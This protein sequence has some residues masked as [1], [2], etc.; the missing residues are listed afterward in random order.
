MQTGELLKFPLPPVPIEI[1]ELAASELEVNIHMYV[2]SINYS[3]GNL[4]KCHLS[5]GFSP[6]DETCGASSIGASIWTDFG[7]KYV[8][9]GVLKR[10]KPSKII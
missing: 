1:E 7:T 3:Q 5:L 8:M 9:T 2:I 4:S 6:Y 10:R